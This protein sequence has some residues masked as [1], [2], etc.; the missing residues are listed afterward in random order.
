MVTSTVEENI[1]KKRVSVSPRGGHEI[2]SKWK[3]W[4]LSKDPKTVGEREVVLSFSNEIIEWIQ[5]TLG[6]CCYNLGVGKLFQ[7][8]T[9]KWKAER[10]KWTSFTT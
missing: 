7:S 3:K 4:H 5:E 6:A 9:L 1:A 8:M 10:K 2:Q